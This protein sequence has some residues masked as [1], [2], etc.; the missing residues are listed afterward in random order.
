MPFL[1]AKNLDVNE[2]IDIVKETQWPENSLLLAFSTARCCFEIFKFDEELLLTTDQ[3]RIFSSAG[4]FRWR[5]IDGRIRAVYLG[6]RPPQGLDDFSEK[7]QKLHTRY[8]DLILWGERTELN[9][10]WLEQQ[11]PKKISYPLQGKEYNCGR[12]VLTIEQWVDDFD[13]PQFSRYQGIKEIENPSYQEDRG[14][15]AAG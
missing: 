14:Y 12:I 4:E 5:R 3:G 15:H 8:E 11:I 13:I 6:E 9:N 2:F 1:S 7:L 10:E